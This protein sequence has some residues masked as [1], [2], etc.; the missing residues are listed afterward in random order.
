MNRSRWIF[1]AFLVLFIFEPTGWAGYGYGKAHFG[2][3]KIPLLL[4]ALGVGYWV[5][6]LSQKQGRPLNILGRVIGGII[7]VVS[8]VGLLCVAV[9]RVASCYK[10]GKFSKAECTYHLPNPPDKQAEKSQ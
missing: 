3:G 4:L 8:F 7:M 2:M 9:S 6:T 10:S 1:L 5:L